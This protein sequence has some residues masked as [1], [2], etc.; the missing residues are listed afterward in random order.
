MSR[1]IAPF[2]MRNFNGVLDMPFESYEAFCGR[3]L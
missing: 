2:V 3:L 1:M